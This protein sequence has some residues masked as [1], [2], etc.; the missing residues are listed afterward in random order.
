MLFLHLSFRTFGTYEDELAWAGAWLNLATG[1]ALYLNKALEHFSVIQTRESGFNWED[2]SLGALLLLA[3]IT[4]DTKYSDPVKAFCTK[5]RNGAVTT[6][7]KGQLHFSEW[8]SLR[9]SSN[10]ALICLQV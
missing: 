1:K 3:R 8:G 7:P 5:L 9:H 10:A 6:S 4:G 2:K